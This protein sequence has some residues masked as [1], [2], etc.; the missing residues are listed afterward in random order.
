MLLLGLA[1]QLVLQFVDLR[2][3]LQQAIVMVLSLAGLFF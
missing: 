2:V 3:E 1:G